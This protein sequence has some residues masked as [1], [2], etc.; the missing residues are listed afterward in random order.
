VFLS[1]SRMG[2]TPPAAGPAPP[3]G[4]ARGA[5]P[6]PAVAPRGGGAGGRGAAQQPIVLSRNGKDFK[7][8]GNQSTVRAGNEIQVKTERQE[9]TLSLAEMDLGSW[10]MFE[11][12]G[13]TKAASGTEQPSMDALRKANATSYFR[14]GNPLWVN[15]V[16]PKPP[17]PIVR[18]TERQAS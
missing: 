15:L 12:P 16:V 11:L 6:A 14:G 4:P 10:V 7:I 8:T 17:L 18:P 1:L 2:E 13:F 3:A 9:V 5:A